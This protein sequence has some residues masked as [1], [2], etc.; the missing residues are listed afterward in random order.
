MN[1]IMAESLDYIAT[2]LEKAGS[3]D[4]AKFNAAI[5]KVI[6]EVL[7]KHGDII[8]NGNGYSEDWRKE[9]EKRGLPNLRSCVDALPIL[10]SK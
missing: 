8:F 6:E 4:P 10:G 5:Q 9:A 3:E 1:T 7:A 2:K